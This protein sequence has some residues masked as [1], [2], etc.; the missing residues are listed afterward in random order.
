M[1]W[2]RNLRTVLLLSAVLFGL[3]LGGR[4][5]EAA[6]FDA[7]VYEVLEHSQE[8]HNHWI[9][10]LH[11]TYGSNGDWA[12]TFLNYNP[13]GTFLRLVGD[14]PEDA[15]SLDDLNHAFAASGTTV[16]NNGFGQWEFAFDNNGEVWHLVAPIAGI[17]DFACYEDLTPDP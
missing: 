8:S 12:I 17:A 6:T 15:Y 16:G 2:N 10:E 9:Y 11:Y 3:V 5:C 7:A 4:P 14:G 1:Q 13:T